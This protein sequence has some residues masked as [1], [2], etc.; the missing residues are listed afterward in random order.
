[1]LSKLSVK[2]IISFSTLLFIGNVLP[3]NAELKVVSK[4]DLGIDV[5]SIEQ[6]DSFG[7]PDS[8]LI[9]STFS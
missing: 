2:L 4:E 6:E 7:S 8:V 9:Y 5:S 1:M 3:A